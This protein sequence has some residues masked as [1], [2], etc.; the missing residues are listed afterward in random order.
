MQ[1]T[2]FKNELIDIIDEK[3][4]ES[5]SG[6]PEV[7]DV[8][9]GK[10]LT[11]DSSG[12]WA[13]EMP[14]GGVATLKLIDVTIGESNPIG[15]ALSDSDVPLTANDMLEICANNYVVLK[16]TDEEGAYFDLRSGVFS[17]GALNVTGSIGLT[18]YTDVS[19]A[20]LFVPHNADLISPLVL[21]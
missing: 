6:L 10:V 2:Q 9:E 12:E 13:A 7:T 16:I 8:D 3:I 19:N 14:S 15:I 20:L 11:V 5:G 17:F 1:D 18:F 4:A 21:D